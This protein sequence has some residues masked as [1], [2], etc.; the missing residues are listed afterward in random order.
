MTTPQDLERQFTLVTAT[1]RY[2][3][4]RT[5]DAIAPPAGSTNEP[6]PPLE[7]GIPLSQGEA[8][9]M[10]AL[11]EVIARKAAYGR[12]LAVRTARAVG[13][14]WSQIGQALGTTK[15]SA[16]EAH[17]RW[18]DDQADQHRHNGYQGWDADEVTAARALAG[19]LDDAPAAGPA[20]TTPPHSR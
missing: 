11:G 10:L 6:D 12:Q 13:A 20:G 2:D 9:Q 3:E 5:R 7:H 18:I 16:W 14:S 15:Q 4:L 8:L 19:Q 1:V 17:T